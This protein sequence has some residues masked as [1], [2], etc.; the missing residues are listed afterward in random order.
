MGQ[1]VMTKTPIITFSNVSFS[2]SED[3][4]LFRGLSFEL[5]KGAFHLIVGPSGSGKSTLLRLI[6]RLEEPLDGEILQR[7]ALVL[8]PSSRAQTVYSL[9]SA[10]SDR[11]RG[12]GPG[13]PYAALYL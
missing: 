11:Y 6:N 1:E 10:N 8:F 7:T 13:K 5:A 2:F 4:P 3:Q 12:H 9:Y